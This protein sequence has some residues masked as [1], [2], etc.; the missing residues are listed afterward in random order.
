MLT[1]FL[2]SRPAIH[3]LLRL[4]ASGKSA[5]ANRPRSHP[6]L[7]LILTRFSPSRP[8]I[9]PRPIF[10]LRFTFFLLEK[11]PPCGRF[12]FSNF[13]SRLFLSNQLTRIPSR[14][15]PLRR[16]AFFAQRLPA[17]TFFTSRKRNLGARLRQQSGEFGGRQL[18]P[19][20]GT[21]FRRRVQT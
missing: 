15:A 1:R 6:N 14:G 4:A 2:P 9:R 16:P 21:D 11:I 19:R 8:A 12:G 5:F 13:R 17:D 20:E 10:V 18:F 3:R 7:R